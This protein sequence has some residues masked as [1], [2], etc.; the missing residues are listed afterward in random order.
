MH[1]RAADPRPDGGGGG[2]EAVG[3]LRRHTDDRHRCRWRWAFRQDLSG[4]GL[5]FR[6]SG[7]YGWGATAVRDGSGPISA[8]LQRE[9]GGG[10][11]TGHRLDGWPAPRSPRR[12]H[13]GC[14][15]AGDPISID[16]PPRPSVGG[17]AEAGVPE[18]RHRVGPLRRPRHFMRHRRPLGSHLAM[19]ADE[20][21]NR[22]VVRG[23]VSGLGRQHLDFRGGA[24]CAGP[25]PDPGGDGDLPRSEAR[26]QTLVSDRGDV[27]VA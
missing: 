16:R 5:P 8:V 27:H 15:W 14:C 22:P 4:A 2:P 21:A 10:E 11:G 26:D 19:S 13:R 3:P 18:R 7:L 17:C 25:I 9:G 12:L 23:A 6:P 1:E 20:P 24:P